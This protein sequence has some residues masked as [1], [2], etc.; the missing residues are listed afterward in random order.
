MPVASCSEH[1]LR[2]SGDFVRAV[3]AKK[4]VGNGRMRPGSCLAECNV[5]AATQAKHLT[6]LQAGHGAWNTNTSA[7]AVFQM[8]HSDTLIKGDRELKGI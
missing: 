1:T 7:T 4:S 3:H 6:S 5:L 8:I 2:S